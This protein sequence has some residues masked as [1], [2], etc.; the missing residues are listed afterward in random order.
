MALTTELLN[1]NALTSGL[2]DEQKQAITEMSR[3]DETAVIGQ[4]VGEIYGG[5]DN[6]ILSAS[7]IAKNGTEKTYDYAKRVI[8]ELKSQSGDVAAKQKEIDTLTKEKARLEGVI[9]SGGSDAETK[10]ALNQAKADL[11]NVTKEYTELKTK[12]DDA[13]KNYAKELM[14]VRMEGEF[15]KASTGVKFKADL[16]KTVTDVLMGQAIAKVKGM[17]PEY[18]DDG[19]GGK[20]LAFMQ[21]GTPMR[22]PERNLNPYTAAEL[23]EKQLR[24]MGV[25]ET[26]RKQ[27]GAG[28]DP[29]QGGKGGGATVDLSAA[30]T[31]SEANEIITKQLMQQGLTVGSKEFQD[32]MSKAWTDNNDRIKALPI[33]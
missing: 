27:T 29:N 25:L 21:D 20:V 2:T 13:E 23:V 16:P 31:Q 15:A 5:L 7:G 11:A 3:N 22:N 14:N 17:N 18:I 26:P 32:A 1:A 24:E 19:K 12:Y 4:R 6:D 28:T 8:G 33:K 9:A 10:K 30:R